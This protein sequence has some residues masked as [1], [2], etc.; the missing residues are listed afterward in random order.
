MA[1]IRTGFTKVLPKIISHE[2]PEK[3]PGGSEEQGQ[4]ATL[5]EVLVTSGSIATTESTEGF[6]YHSDLGIKGQPG[7]RR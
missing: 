7:P 6:G 4:Y 5:T 2:P 1:G 3:L